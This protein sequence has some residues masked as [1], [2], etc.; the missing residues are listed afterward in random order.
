[1]CSRSPGKE[2]RV[3]GRGEEKGGWE[4][5]ERQGREE[6]GGAGEGGEGGEGAGR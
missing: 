3:R 4:V 6:K 1:M 5:R 2:G